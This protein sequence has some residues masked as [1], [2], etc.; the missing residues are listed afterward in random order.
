VDAVSRWQWFGGGGSCGGVVGGD[1]GLA[2]VAVAVVVLVAPA[3]GRGGLGMAR[4]GWRRHPSPRP[5]GALGFKTKKKE[6]TEL[7]IDM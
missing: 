2:A 1:S 7:L 3:D 6:G 4:C 5:I